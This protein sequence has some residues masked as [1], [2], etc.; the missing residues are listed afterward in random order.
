MK[1]HKLKLKLKY[2]IALS[3]IAFFSIGFIFDC[4]WAKT[5]DIDIAYISNETPYAD[6]KE[7]VTIKVQVTHFNKPC[8]NHEIYALPSAGSMVAYTTKTDNDGY[9]TLTYTP[10]TA[11][12]FV[13]L[14]D[15]EIVIRDQSNSIIWEVNARTSITLKMVKKPKD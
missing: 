1:K 13:K 11:T 3:L 2:I 7:R 15:V 9:A 5:Y 4:I 12:A 8:K 6:S 10:Y 14:E